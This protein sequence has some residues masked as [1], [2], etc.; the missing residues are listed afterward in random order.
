MKLLALI[1]LSFVA[2]METHCSAVQPRADVA[3]SR[4]LP[5]PACSAEFAGNTAPRLVNTKLAQAA[6]PICHEGYAVLFSGL[7][8]TP[9]WSAERLTPARVR[10]ARRIE[11]VDDSHPDAA[12]P[13]AMGANLADYR[14][15]GYDRGH[16]APSGDM[17]TPGSQEESF[18]LANIVPQT[19][20]LNRHAW[21]DIEHDVRELALMAPR[22]FVVTGPLFERDEL[23]TLNHRIAVPTSIYKAVYVPGRGAVAIVASNTARPVIRT[24]SLDQFTRLSGIEPFPTAPAGDKRVI[25]P[26][27]GTSLTGRPR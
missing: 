13:Q 21:S 3:A 12:L 22:V 11:R 8:R 17:A 24:L 20:A 15:S 2:T 1:V 5:L 6:V 19:P 14:G 26:L 7:T 9:L 10:A 4:I 27:G 16:M 23:V 25:M 18:S